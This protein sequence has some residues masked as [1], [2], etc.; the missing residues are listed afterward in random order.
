MKKV[1]LPVYKCERC[2]A[3]ITAIGPRYNDYGMSQFPCVDAPL[4]I[5]HTCKV[6]VVS[7]ARL[8]GLNREGKK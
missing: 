5:A 8:I 2:G 7:I 6:G 1:W 3:E 4:I